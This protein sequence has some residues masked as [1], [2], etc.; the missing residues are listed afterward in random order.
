LSR[1]GFTAGLPG[2]PQ[3]LT[4]MAGRLGDGS[5]TDHAEAL[6]RVPSP[7]PQSRDERAPSSPS[8]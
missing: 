2:A 7:R 3:P 1:R 5:S 4:G 8:G 6:L